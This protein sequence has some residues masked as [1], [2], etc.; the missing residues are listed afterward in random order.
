MKSIF[1]RILLTLLLITGCDIF[2]DNNDE[3]DKTKWAELK[4]PVVTL[5]L[6]ST[7][8]FDDGNNTY[9]IVNAVTA[10]V[11]GSITKV[12]CSGESGGSFNYNTTFYPKDSEYNVLTSIKIG[13]DYQFKFEN[14]KDY[15]QLIFRARYSFDDGK[16]FESSE[17]VKKVYYSDIMIDVNS[18][19]NKIL[20]NIDL[21]NFFLVTE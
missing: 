21:A 9:S 7:G 19:E 14:D 2:K 20:M 13:Q 11:S 1:P 12:Y 10:N 17:V 5:R 18:M 15:L 8:S 16:T 3:C 4:E 6:D